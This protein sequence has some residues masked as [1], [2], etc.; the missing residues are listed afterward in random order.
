MTL[1]LIVNGKVSLQKYFVGQNSKIVKIHAI[2][3]NIFQENVSQPRQNGNM[4]VVQE[5]KIDFFLG[6]T[7]SS[8]T[9]NIVPTFGLALFLKKMMK[10]MGAS[11]HAQ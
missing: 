11:V 7:N 4:L 2:Y 3:L 1:L 6:E 8:R 10:K 9:I 5:K